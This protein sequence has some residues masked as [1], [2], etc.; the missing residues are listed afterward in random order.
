MASAIPSVQRIPDRF[1]R[2]LMRFLQAPSTGPLA[3]G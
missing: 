2:S 3:M 1:M